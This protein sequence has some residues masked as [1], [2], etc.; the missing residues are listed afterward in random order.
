M[1]SCVV[2]VAWSLSGSRCLRR[3]HDGG[4]TPA[5]IEAAWQAETARTGPRI[6][7]LSPRP[8]P[9]ALRARFYPGESRDGLAAPADEARRLL[10]EAGLG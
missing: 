8:M 2:R 6:D 3:A 9:T 10:G 7:I 1:V 5:E 4:A